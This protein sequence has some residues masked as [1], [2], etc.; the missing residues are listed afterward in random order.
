MSDELGER[1][2]EDTQV[3]KKTGIAQG[4]RDAIQEGGEM[5]FDHYCGACEYRKTKRV[6]YSR[7]T[8][9]RWKMCEK[10]L[11]QYDSNRKSKKA[12]KQACR[13]WSREEEWLSTY[14]FHAAKGGSAGNM[15]H[16]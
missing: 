8:F 14:D 4:R 11:S 15:N 13:Y 1:G 3:G 7:E 12:H 2:T 5:N 6:G 16:R 10:G 9:P